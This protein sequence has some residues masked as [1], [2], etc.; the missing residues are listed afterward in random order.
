VGCFV[1]SLIARL[2]IGM[3]KRLCA[4]PGAQYNVHQLVYYEVHADVHEAILGEKKI[5]KWRRQW[6]INLIERDNPH[7]SNLIIGLF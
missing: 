7:W 6:K 4:M 3:I 1:C 5:K 2:T